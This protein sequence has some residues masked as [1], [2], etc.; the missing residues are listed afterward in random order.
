MSREEGP[1][2]EMP[3]GVS[4]ESFEK[5][6]FEDNKIK[7]TEEKNIKK[8]KK[9]Q[10]K[11]VTSKKKAERK[12]IESIKPDN[13]HAPVKD[14]HTHGNRKNRFIIPAIIAG[15]LVVAVI[16]FV[17][18]RFSDNDR[19]I[20]PDFDDG[21]RVVTLTRDDLNITFYG[22]DGAGTVY[23]E[24]DTD[25]I[26]PKIL[27]CMGVDVEDPGLANKTQARSLCNEYIA[28]AV[29]P[30]ASGEDYKDIYNLYSGDSYN[31]YNG[32]TFEIVL[33]HESELEEN[34]DENTPSDD[35]IVLQLEKTVVECKGLKEMSEKDI[36]ED[37]FLALSGEDGKLT[38]KCVYT[39]GISHIASGHFYI[40]G[41]NGSFSY[42]DEIW[43]SISDAAIE[44]LYSQEGIILQRES[45]IYTAERKGE[46][47][48]KLRDITDEN[49]A[50]MI[51]AGIKK[52]SD[53]AANSPTKVVY[54]GMEYYGAYLYSASK[55]DDKASGIYNKLIIVYTADVYDGET[56][57]NSYGIYIPVI[58]ENIVN[59]TDGTQ[60]IGD[61]ISFRSNLHQDAEW[62]TY[63]FGYY[64]EDELRHA[65]Q[66]YNTC[67]TWDSTPE[68]PESLVYGE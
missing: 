52:V 31:L 20:L 62:G 44:R 27:E 37:V 2:Y 10:P 3:K 57:D 28:L 4:L 26:V 41:E 6:T 7:I 63:V 16:V 1:R 49:M 42:G 18:I 66:P 13:G 47:V 59:E 36:F 55:Y 50:Y 58:F 67:L 48:T 8:P 43:V 53:W 65:I 40:E 17:I 21:D 29:F 9:E 30:E 12:P 23:I 68:L 33:C 22:Y 35:D 15:A 34:G 54:T 39:G 32:Q 46:V 61:K 19:K 64:A 38:A 60:T 51:D 25:R 24:L 5:F 14:I 56:L 11:K 45:C